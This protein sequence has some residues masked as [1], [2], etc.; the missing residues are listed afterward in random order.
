MEA[1]RG[2]A[3]YLSYSDNVTLE[4]NR[5]INNTAQQGGAVYVYHSEV[6]AT[7]NHFQ[8]NAAVSGGD[9]GV[10]HAVSV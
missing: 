9:I 8:G 5:F 2:G 3:I 6:E 7:D 10:A 4:K 1:I